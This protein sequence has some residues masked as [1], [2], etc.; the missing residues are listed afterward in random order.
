MRDVV[1]LDVVMLDVIM[2]SL[3]APRWSGSVQGTNVFV[4]LINTIKYCTGF[5]QK[6]FTT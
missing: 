5:S 2:L 4:F 1:M 3:V 6:H